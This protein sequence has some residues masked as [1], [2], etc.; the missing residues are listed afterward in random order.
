MMAGGCQF[1][2]WPTAGAGLP[3]IDGPS[4][5]P[6]F[7]LPLIGWAA[8]RGGVTSR[9]ALGE[10]DAECFATRR[11]RGINETAM[12]GNRR[13]WRVR[14]APLAALRHDAGGAT[15]RHRPPKQGN[16]RPNCSQGGSGTPPLRH[17]ERPRRRSSRSST[18]GR[19]ATITRR[20]RHLVAV[21][22]NSLVEATVDR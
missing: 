9:H 21:V 13:G 10:R 5:Q 7:H 1:C 2:P 15:A 16:T 12:G 19:G 14:G 18:C 11:L 17:S 3:A 6:E 20:L 4:T 8:R 22:G